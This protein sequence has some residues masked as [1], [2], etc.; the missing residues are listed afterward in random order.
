[1]ITDDCIGNYMF[2]I[3]IYSYDVNPVLSSYYEHYSQ[4][5]I[6]MIDDQDLIIRDK[7]GHQFFSREA[8][9]F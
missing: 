8:I 2:S 1:M 6:L 4:K 3:D 9:I 7:E 5:E